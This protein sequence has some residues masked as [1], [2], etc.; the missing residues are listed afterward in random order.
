MTMSFFSKVRLA[1]S[2]LLLIVKSIVFG[3]F[4]IIWG[5]FFV[6]HTTYIKGNAVNI[7]EKTLK[8]EGLSSEVARELKNSY[9]FRWR[10]LVR[11]W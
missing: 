2:Y 6:L 9:N 3:S 11:R 4:F 10:D 8:R 7:F 5:I 1:M